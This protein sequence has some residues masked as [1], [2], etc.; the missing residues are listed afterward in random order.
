MPGMINLFKR[1]FTLKTMASS[2]VT[3]TFFFLLFGLKLMI[4]GNAMILTKNILKASLERINP[5]NL[6]RIVI[7]SS[8]NQDFFLLNQNKIQMTTCVVVNW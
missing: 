7:G 1:S 4:K 2:L 6:L 8:S 3:E 5:L